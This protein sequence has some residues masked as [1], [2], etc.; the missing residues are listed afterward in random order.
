MATLAVC[1]RLDDL[2]DTQSDMAVASVELLYG[3]CQHQAT[4]PA[5]QTF[6]CKRNLDLF[7]RKNGLSILMD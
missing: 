2:T 1:L 6:Q 7:F 4:F 3:E 5:F